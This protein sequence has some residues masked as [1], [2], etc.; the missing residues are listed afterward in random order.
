M[1]ITY[2]RISQN[3]CV[4][5]PSSRA[6]LVYG[7]QLSMIIIMYLSNDPRKQSPVDYLSISKDTIKIPLYAEVITEQCS[8]KLSGKKHYT[9]ESSS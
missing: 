9:V 7:P 3:S 8:Q 5:K 2:N 1:R 4:P 6:G